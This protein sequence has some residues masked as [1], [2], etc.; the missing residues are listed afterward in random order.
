MKTDMEMI[1]VMTHVYDVLVGADCGAADLLTVADRLL[2]CAFANIAPQLSK[3]EA[4]SLADKTLLLIR[5][6]I[7]QRIS[8][9]LPL[10]GEA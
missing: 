9:P 3:S 10:Q 4:Q 2:T 1:E 8:Q 6:H 5:R 7:D